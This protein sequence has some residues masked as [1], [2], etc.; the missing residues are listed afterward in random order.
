MADADSLSRQTANRVNWGLVDDALG[1]AL[2]QQGP[3]R[4]GRADR[5]RSGV[6][7]HDHDALQDAFAVVRSEFLRVLDPLRRQIALVTWLIFG[8]VAMTIAGG[9][10][11]FLQPVGGGVLT[12]AG[13]G[14][15]FGLILKAWQLAR[16]QAM[17]E[18][19]P[20]RYELALRFAQSPAQSSELIRQFMTE[21]SSIRG[22]RR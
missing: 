20:A 1:A 19:V 18:L 17:L 3:D 13:V 9:V 14:T 16:D 12:L 10:L 6:V 11:A 5:K 4:G 22:P 7:G 8:S 15:L 2:D 21:T